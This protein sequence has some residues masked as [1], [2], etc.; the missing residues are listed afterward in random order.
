MATDE[1]GLT[2]K[3]DAFACAYVETGN[4]SEAYRRAYD[5]SSMKEE[6]IWRKA[7]ECLDN[8]KVTARVEQLQA[9]HAERHNVTIDRLTDELELARQGAI[10]ASSSAQLLPPSWPRPSCMAFSTTT[11]WS[12][13]ERDCLP[14]SSTLCCTALSPHP[15]GTLHVI[16]PLCRTDLGTR[17]LT[18]V[19]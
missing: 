7:K 8:G 19:R 1:H 9:A 16:E 17:Q 4:A 11:G 13:P 12:R 15:N 2:P 6:T 10:A 14:R 3:Q 18:G 5:A